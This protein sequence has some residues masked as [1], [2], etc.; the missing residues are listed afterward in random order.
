MTHDEK[1]QPKSSASPRLFTSEGKPVKVLSTSLGI[2]LLASAVL[3]G[4]G[5][6]ATSATGSE[7]PKLVSWSSEEVKAYF[8]ATVDWS[9][10][11]PSLEEDQTEAPEEPADGGASPTVIHHYGSGFG[12][13]D[14]LLY[15]LLFN[16]G[17]S[18]SSSGYYKNRPAYYSTNKARYTPKTYSSDTFQNKQVAGSTVKPKTSSTTGTITRRSTSS[19]PGG[20]GG[21]SSSLSSSGSKSSVSSGV[22]SGRS[23]G[24]GG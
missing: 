15:H 21:K 23:S 14:L 24:F 8:D 17:G 5:V 19:S 7:Q 16:N 12:W 20:I 10:P 4:T 3:G 2:A 13:D 9:L 18:Y 22:S 11:M 6:S 1:Q